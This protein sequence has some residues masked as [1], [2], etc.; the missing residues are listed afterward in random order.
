[1]DTLSTEIVQSRSIFGSSTR[2]DHSSKR[3]RT[4]DDTPV[5]GADQWKPASLAL[6]VKLSVAV[7]CLVLKMSEAKQAEVQLLFQYIPS[8]NCVVVEV[9]CI[10]FF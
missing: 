3:Q 4:A 10:T 7:K 6:Q 5:E 2:A 8:I 9:L 1:M